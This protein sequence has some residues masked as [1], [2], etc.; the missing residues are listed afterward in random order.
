[1]DRAKIKT[2]LLVIAL[3]SVS[4]WAQAPEGNTVA[5]L[6][7]SALWAT[8]GLFSFRSDRAEDWNYRLSSFLGVALATIEGTAGLLG[9]GV[10][11]GLL[12]MAVLHLAA[13]LLAVM[14]RYQKVKSQRP[15]RGL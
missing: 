13:F 6:A 5:L 10:R 1:M 9:L 14:G 7:A 15:S 4:Y 12:G 2:A 8:L 11:E 3:A